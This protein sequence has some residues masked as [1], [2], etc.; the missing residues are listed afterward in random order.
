MLHIAEYIWLDGDR[1]TQKLRSKTRILSVPEGQSPELTDFPVWSFDGSSTY[2][3]SGHD[4][5]LLLRPVSVVADPIRGAAHHLVLAE[6]LNADGTPHAT[7]QRAELEAVLAAGAADEEP[8]IGF[9][10]EYTSLKARSPGLAQR[11]LP[12]AQGPFYCGVGST[13][14]LWTRAGRRAR[15]RACHRG[16]ADDLWHQRRSH[17]GSVGVSDWLP[18]PRRGEDAGPLN[19]S[20]QLWLARW[21]LERLGE[22]FGVRGRRARPQAGAR[23]IGTAP[24]PTPT[25]PLRSMRSAGSGLDADQVAA[26]ERGCERDARRPH[27]GN[28]GVGFGRSA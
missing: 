16:R 20:D 23:R 21:L 22:K 27:P 19:V 3:A 18:R 13:H 10:Q 17:A 24:V 25:S 14:D 6:V 9:E 8:W 11:R 1:P 2:Q 5:D 26:I 7:N 12:R 15:T 4:S 28:Y